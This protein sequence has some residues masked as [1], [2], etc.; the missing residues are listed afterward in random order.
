MEL[1][2]NIRKFNSNFR[3]KIVLKISKLKE[4]KDLVNVFNII[5]NELGKELSINRNGIFFNINLL[6]DTC[7]LGLEKYLSENTDLNS[8]T[9]TENKI[10]YKPYSVDEL[11]TVNKL[12]PKLS[13]QEKSLLKKITKI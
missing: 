1:D 6:S 9:E 10:K 8:I 12:G 4:K 3:R 7:I 2:S 11:E 5:Q 13:N